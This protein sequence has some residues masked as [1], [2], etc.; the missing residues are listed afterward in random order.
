MTNDPLR[1]RHC[2]RTGGA[3]VLHVGG[4]YEGHIGVFSHTGHYITAISEEE[5]GRI[6]ILDP[7][8]KEGKFDEDGRRGKVEV[9]NGIFCFCEMQVITEDT[10][11]RTPGMYLFWRN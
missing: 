6:V 10:E 9:R 5:D 2:L 11:S 7:S 4:D 3:A 1:L 8:Y